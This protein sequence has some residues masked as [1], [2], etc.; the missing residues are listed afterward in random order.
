MC[1]T[2][3]PKDGPEFDY[4]GWMEGDGG[5]TMPLFNVRW[6]GHAKDGSTVDLRERYSLERESDYSQRMEFAMFS[7]AKRAYR[8]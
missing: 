7:M 2:N 5:Q 6:P 8:G 3:M 1:L 4:I